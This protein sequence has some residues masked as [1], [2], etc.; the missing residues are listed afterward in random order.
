MN[1]ARLGLAAAVLAFTSPCWAALKFIGAANC[2]RS[3][4][5]GT[6]QKIESLVK[7]SGTGYVI[8]AQQFLADKSL[9]SDPRIGLLREILKQADQDPKVDPILRSSLAYFKAHMNMVEVIFAF[10][11]SGLESRASASASASYSTI[12]NRLVI[13]PNGVPVG[14]AYV[15]DAAPPADPRFYVVFDLAKLAGAPGG[16]M[17]EVLH[18][19]THATDVHRLREAATRIPAWPAY[20]QVQAWGGRI[21]ISHGSLSLIL[22]ARAYTGEFRTLQN[23]GWLKREHVEGVLRALLNDPNLTG[24]GSG[25]PFVASGILDGSKFSVPAFF[26]LADALGRWF[27]N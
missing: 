3:L 14:D 8:N 7:G 16:G 17:A 2:E 5:A 13:V 20:A 15:D 26:K 18:E 6:E 22:E 21:Y 27:P 25:D 4:E 10:L 24:P 19:L 23:F 1:F 12:Q 9:I 11:D